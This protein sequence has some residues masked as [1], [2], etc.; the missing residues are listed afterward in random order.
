MTLERKKATEERKLAEEL[1][2]QVCRLAPPLRL[3]PTQLARLPWISSVREKPRAYDEKPAVR[4][5]LP[6]DG[7]YVSLGVHNHQFDPDPPK[8][9]SHASECV[10]RLCDYHSKGIPSCLISNVCSK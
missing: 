8:L 9:A 5:R 3:I 1:K 2:A 6:I 10:R 4:R 7:L